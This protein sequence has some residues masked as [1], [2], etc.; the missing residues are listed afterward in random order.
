MASV[1]I[2]FWIFLFKAYSIVCPA[3]KGR[4]IIFAVSF[5]VFDSSS[6]N[7]Q[8]SESW[9]YCGRTT[10]DSV[11]LKSLKKKIGNFIPIDKGQKIG[12]GEMNSIGNHFN[13]INHLPNRCDHIEPTKWLNRRFESKCR[14]S[15]LKKEES[16]I[17]V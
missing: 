4:W 16:T 13:Q 15:I 1:Q 11:C 14:L 6:Q 17:F 7:K 9:I 10:K 12:T 5:G 8:N 3:V 2:Q